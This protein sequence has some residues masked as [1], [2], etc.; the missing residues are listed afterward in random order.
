MLNRRTVFPE[1]LDERREVVFKE[2]HAGFAMVQDLDQFRRGE[3][4]I[5]RR[6]NCAGLNDAEVAFQQLV[7][8]EAQIGDAVAG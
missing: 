6:H 8:I 7:R 3:A 2:H 4:N 5:E 1:V